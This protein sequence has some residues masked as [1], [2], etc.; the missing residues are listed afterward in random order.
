ME[1]I[2]EEVKAFGL[3]ERFNTDDIINF[4]EYR[5]DED[6][7]VLIVPH[8]MLGDC[9]NINGAIRYILHFYNKVYVMTM[10]HYV[11]NIQMIYNDIK[12]IQVIPAYENEIANIVNNFK[13]DIYSLNFMHNI[14]TKTT[15]PFLSTKFNKTL[16]SKHFISDMYQ[17][18]NLDMRIYNDYFHIVPTYESKE[19]YEILKS[20]R[21]IFAHELTSICS[22]DLTPYLNHSEDEIVICANRNIYSEGIK[23][24]LAQKFVNIP[25]IDYY[26]TIV[27]ATKIVI[28]DSCFSS[29]VLPLVNKCIVKTDDITIIHRRDHLFLET[30][31]SKIKYISG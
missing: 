15:H 23:R 17:L 6:K 13:G 12:Y 24:E 16:Y 22:F 9:I 27:N 26:D 18:A 31:C 21:V 29:I 7:E 25:I 14:K 10:P 20:Y 11:K 30:I 3:S 19:L 8:L 5:P 4:I 28:S 2:I 1:A